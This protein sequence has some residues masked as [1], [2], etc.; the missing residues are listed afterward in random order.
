MGHHRGP[1]VLQMAD[2]SL[3]TNCMTR[4][5]STVLRVMLK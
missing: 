4:V 5:V 1:M 3:T 2:K